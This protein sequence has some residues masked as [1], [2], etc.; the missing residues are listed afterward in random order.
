MILFERSD[1]RLQIQARIK[2]KLD[3]MRKSLWSGYTPKAQDGVLR[4]FKLP[5]L[6]VGM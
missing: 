4:E 1:C 2:V 6:I 3:V 5:S